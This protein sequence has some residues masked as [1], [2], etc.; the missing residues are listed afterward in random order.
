[1]VKGACQKTL[2]DLKLDY[3]DLYLIH[4]PTGF[5]VGGSGLRPDPCR[6]RSPW[7]VKAQVGTRSVCRRPGLRTSSSGQCCHLGA[8]W[9]SASGPTGPAAREPWAARLHVTKFEE[10]CALSFAGGTV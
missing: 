10:P 1:M 7:C 3:L 8:C 5:K 4:W 6:S 9:R 2:S